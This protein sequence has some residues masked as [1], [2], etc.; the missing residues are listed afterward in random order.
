MR[1]ELPVLLG[2]AAAASASTWTVT[3]YKGTSCQGQSHTWS[4]DS[5]ATQNTGDWYN[6]I[7]ADYPSGWTF[8][9]WAG[10][11]ETGGSYKPATAVCEN[12]ANGDAFLSFT[13]SQ[14]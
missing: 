10:A 3:A 4:G 8:T 12:S 7:V 11:G 9:A 13:L 1:F 2:L 6:S 5:D 14:G